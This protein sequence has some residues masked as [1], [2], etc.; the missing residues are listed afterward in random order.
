M[1]QKA[2]PFRPALGQLRRRHREAPPRRPKLEKPVNKVS[3]RE[4]LKKGAAA[5]A[6]DHEVEHRE[7]HFSTETREGRLH[8]TAE[9]VRARA[10]G[11]RGRGGGGR[12]GCPEDDGRADRG[13]RAHRR[14]PPTPVAQLLQRLAQGGFPQTGE[15]V[16][17]ETDP[18]GVEKGAVG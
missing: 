12:L 17:M 8:R 4:A 15:R 3:E 14:A 7:D 2:P 6:L 18:T 5:Q 13:E 9:A 11:W 16:G 10:C 1:G